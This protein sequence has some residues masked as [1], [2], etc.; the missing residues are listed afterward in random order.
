MVFDQ[1]TPSANGTMVSVLGRLHL[2]TFEKIYRDRCNAL[3]DTFSGEALRAYLSMPSFLAGLE[4]VITGLQIVIVGPLSS[5]KTHEL[6]AAVMGRSLPNRTLLVVD[7][8]QPIAEGH[9]AYGKKM[10]NAQPTAYI[11]QRSTCST[12][13]TNPVTL[14]QA[15]QLPPRAAG[16]A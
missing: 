6:V 15:L 3:I 7:P 9:P 14:S 16:Q 1:A 4:L 11:C 12:P 10:E 13:I 5:P 2:V 8:D